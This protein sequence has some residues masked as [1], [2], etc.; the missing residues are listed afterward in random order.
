MAEVSGA[1]DK[2]ELPET[3]TE[4]EHSTSTCLYIENI[5]LLP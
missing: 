1:G 3:E 5:M 2:D 4:P